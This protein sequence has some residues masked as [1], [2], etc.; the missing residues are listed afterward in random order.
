VL[1][2][3]IRELTIIAINVFPLNEIFSSNEN[4]LKNLSVQLKRQIAKF[5]ANNTFA[6]ETAKYE[7]HWWRFEWK[8][9]KKLL[10]C[11]IVRIAY[12][13]PFKDHY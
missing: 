13:E 6:G 2:N 9:A 11:H 7:S 5:N 10:P 4:R 12:I 1:L 8:T 3:F